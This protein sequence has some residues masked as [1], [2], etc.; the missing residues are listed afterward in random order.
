MMDQWNIL[1]GTAFNRDK[2]IARPNDNIDNVK[3]VRLLRF[4]FRLYR[5]FIETCAPFIPPKRELAI[6][7][8]ILRIDVK[9]LSKGRNKVS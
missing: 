5:S 1:Q 3:V 7:S 2:L 9:L 8:L 4:S 6:T